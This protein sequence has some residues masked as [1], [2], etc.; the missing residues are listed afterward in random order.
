MVNHL[1]GATSPIQTSLSYKLTN[2]FRQRWLYQTIIGDVKKH[3]KEE[4]A[5]NLQ[6]EEQERIKS[7][8]E[9]TLKKVRM[10]EQKESTP[11]LTEPT[12]P[13]T[14]RK[15]KKEK[16]KTNLEG[17]YTVYGAVE[18][19]GKAEQTIRSYQT[20]GRI[21]GYKIGNQR[22]YKKEELDKLKIMDKSEE[23]VAQDVENAI[24]E[25]KKTT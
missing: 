1:T 9:S 6:K 10:G 14:K 20:A 23:E 3:V 5:T 18:Y 8:L 13:T 12:K 15:K 22:F 2:Y 17:D 4:I 16:L 19:L 7:I 25:N 11:E 21:K 24:I